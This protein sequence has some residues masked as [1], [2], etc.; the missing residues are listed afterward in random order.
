MNIQQILNRK[1]AAV[2]TIPRDVIATEIVAIMADRRIGTV[3]VTE[4]D[5]RLIGIVSERDVIK[6]LARG[7]VDI[8]TMRADALMTHPVITC[9]AE[10][11][12]EDVLS[13]MSRHSIRHLP[14][15]RGGA[16]AGIV[17]AR[18]ILD[19]QRELLLED[20]ERRRRAEREI[21][22]AKDEAELSSRAKTEFLANMSH[23]LRTP[24]HAIIGFA[25]VL[26]APSRGPVDG[27]QT[28]E[29]AGEIRDAGRHLLEIVDDI[30]DMSRIET[31]DRQP[32]DREVEVR[33][34]SL[35]CLERVRER[36]DRA[37]IKMTC[38]IAASLPVLFAD[39]R[40]VK[41]MLMNLLTNAV[42]FSPEGG[43]VVVRARV[44][45]AGGLTISV[46]DNGIGIAADKM[47][48]VL[49][50]FS[51]IDGSLMRRNEGTGLGLALVN[52]MM[53][54]HDGEL[55]IDSVPGRGTTVSLRFPAHRAIGAGAPRGDDQT[56]ERQT[57]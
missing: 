2:V 56:P 37:H 4:Q 49:A 36:A 34:A 35:S 31:G 39:E 3:L 48:T 50:P 30:L 13:E 42:K 41:Q 24:L 53:G 14:V 6:R 23:E 57:A 11:A 27:E 9:S 16:L 26:T 17:S 54:L 51:Q 8:L 21:L 40:M 1:G 43:D 18:D 15:L 28:Q 7:G 55:A 44:E 38:D 10:T 12:L 45:G 25:E 32:V 46:A 19:L 29:Y 22:R 47:E 20:V 33:Q 5:G 52:A